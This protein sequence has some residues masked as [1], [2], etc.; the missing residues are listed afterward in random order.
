M[1]ILILS[2]NDELYSTKRLVEAAQKL[3]HD[4]EAM[5]YL[6]CSVFIE[7]GNPI[8]NCD[9]RVIS[10]GCVNG[11]PCE[12][13][14]AVIPRIGASK[15]FYG[16]AVVRQFEMMKVFT[17]A[18]SIAI[19]RSRDKLRT[20]QI[21]AKAGIGLPRTVFTSTPG[22]IKKLISLVEGPP[23]IIKVLEGTQGIGVVLAESIKAARS[24]IEAFDGLKVNILIQEFIKESDGADIRAFVI[25]GKVVAAMRRQCSQEEFRSNIHRGGAAGKVSLSA[26]EKA[27]AVNAAKALG[28]SVAGVDLLQSNRGP[29]VVEVNSSP[30]LEGIETVTGVD[31]AGKIIKFIEKN[32]H[33][34]K[35]LKDKVGA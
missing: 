33:K 3:G 2:R 8:I 7:Q 20:L 16:S 22:D 34:Q 18:K 4:A 9:G 29:L 19:V 1:K 10:S 26:N 25:E 31:V 11:E 13:I 30:G 5:D 21:L 6:K 12:E 15:T 14:H 35:H 28:L 17:T 23:V 27:A 24:V 32:V